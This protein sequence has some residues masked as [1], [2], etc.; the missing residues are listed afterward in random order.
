MALC[1]DPFISLGL[2]FPRHKL[3]GAEMSSKIL[4][5]SNYTHG[6]VMSQL[7]QQEEGLM[8]LGPREGPFTFPGRHSGVRSKLPCN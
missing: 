3:R 7:I 2:G 6:F 1:T 4:S 5:M 8:A